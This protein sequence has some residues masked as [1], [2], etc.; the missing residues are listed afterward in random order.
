M[1]L[2]CCRRWN[3][4]NVS[5]LVLLGLVLMM[6]ICFCL[7]FLVCLFVNFNYLLK[8]ECLVGVFG[9]LECWCV[10][11]VVIEVEIVLW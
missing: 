10:V 2:V 11:M 8:Y 5:N 4:F 3:V 1:I 7:W 6:N 9:L